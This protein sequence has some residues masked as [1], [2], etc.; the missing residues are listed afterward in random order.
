MNHHPSIPALF[1]DVRRQRHHFSLLAVRASASDPLN[2][3][4]PSNTICSS[5]LSAVHSRRDFRPSLKSGF[6]TLPHVAPA[7]NHCL[8]DRMKGCN[9]PVVC[10][11][12]F[13]ASQVATGECLLESVICRTH[14]RLVIGQSRSSENGTERGEE[15]QRG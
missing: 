9:T 5:N 15:K 10:P 12:S 1:K 8:T 11:S 2:A 4:D 6:P 14:V 3:D 7:D 13:N